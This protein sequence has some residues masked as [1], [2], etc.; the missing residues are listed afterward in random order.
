MIDPLNYFLSFF[1]NPN[2]WG[3]VIAVIFGAIWLTC[4]WPPLVKKPWHWAVMV[5]SAIITAIAISFVQIPLQSI[6]GNA[7]LQKW[8][9]ET[10]MDWLLLSGIPAV[11]IGGLVQEGAKMVPVV[12]YWWRKNM[13]ID[14][15]LGITLGA[16][17]GA[18][19]GILE[20]QGIHNSIIAMGWSWSLT[21][22]TGLEALIPFIDRFFVIAFSTASTALTGYGLAKGKGWQFYLIA[23]ILNV[24][25]NYS[26]LL[27]PAKI[28]SLVQVE[29]FIAIWA[30]IVTGVALWLRWAERAEQKQPDKIKKH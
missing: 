4:F 20:A 23:S 12:I 29:I 16:V 21:Q 10:L 1:Q 27:I 8:G 26:A 9:S 2:V 17:A 22:T 7:M 11:L 14:Y 13:K 24:V 19:F 3:I 25:L 5:G 6:S 18:G 28:F 30:L 15:K